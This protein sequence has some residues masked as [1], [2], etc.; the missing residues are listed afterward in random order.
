MC[1][2]GGGAEGEGKVLGTEFDSV[3]SAL[4]ISSLT[5]L[6]YAACFRTVNNFRY[7]LHAHA[8]LI[9]EARCRT[10]MR[11]LRI[12]RGGGGCKNCRNLSCISQLFRFF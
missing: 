8:S 9:P 5:F 12:A 4:S 11:K 10:N 3:S 1:G 6:L 7:P 2:G